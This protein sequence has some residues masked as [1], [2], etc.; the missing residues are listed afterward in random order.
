M[1]AVEI[2]E[3]QLAAAIAE[4][5]KIFSQQSNFCGPSF[6]LQCFGKRQRP[7][8]TLKHLA[9]GRSWPDSSQQ[10]VFFL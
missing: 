9:S 7:S 1:K 3:A 5:N 4:Q 6:R 10:F 8:V 2:Q